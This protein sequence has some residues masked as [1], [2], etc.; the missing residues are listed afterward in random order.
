MKRCHLIPILFVLLISIPQKTQAQN[1]G[2]AAAAVVGAVVAGAAVAA[3]NEQFKEML[4]LVGTNY[5]LKNYNYEAF[6]LTIDGLDGA[7]NSDPS[8]V[9]I[10]AFQVA[11]LEFDYGNEIADERF[12]LLV[13]LDT[14]WMTSLGVDFTKVTYK[15]FDKDSWNDLIKEYVRLASGF[16]I[17][18]T[19]VPVFTTKPKESNNEMVFKNKGQT[20]YSTDETVAYRYTTITRKGLENR[21]NIIL[22]FKSMGGDSYFV[23]DYSDEFKIIFNERSL[24]FFLKNT[25]RLVQ[26]KR[27][28]VESITNYLN[29]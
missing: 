23:S 28:L 6:N 25:N 3:A 21:G 22:P 29:Q 17:E 27:R 7:Q 26:V 1:K 5:I 20:Y 11:P 10:L 19:D 13:F 4:E 2:S 12:I 9:S 16:E 15:E 14:G 18:V 24:G 8:T